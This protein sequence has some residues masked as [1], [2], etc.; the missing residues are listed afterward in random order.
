MLEYR[1]AIS[2]ASWRNALSGNN[3]A[4]EGISAEV[5]RRPMTLDVHAET[6]LAS[7][8]SALSDK[9]IDTA[10][11]LEGRIFLG[12]VTAVEIKGLIEEFGAG[13]PIGRCPLVSKR[14]LALLANPLEIRK[15]I[16]DS[17][18]DFV[19][20]VNARGELLEV[21]PVQH[22]LERRTYENPV[23]IMAG[24]R[25]LRLRPLTETIPKPLI[26]VGEKPIISYIVE[27]LLE[28][29]F[30]RYIV[31]VN[32]L[33]E[34]IIEYMENCTLPGIAI[35]YITESDV[36]GTA[37]ALHLLVH[38]IDTPFIVHNA[39]VLTKQDI[40]DLL[41]FHLDSKAA[42]TVLGKSERVEVS[43]GVIETDGKN[44]LSSIEEKPSFD[45]LI[46]TGI[47][48]LE[49][50][51]LELVPPRR[52]DMV[53]LIQAVKAKG[54]TVAVYETKKYWRDVGTHET[55]AQVVRDISN[56]LL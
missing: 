51:V 35:E 53:E 50:E 34:Q 30:Y 28:C 46:S 25:G 48:V 43:F 52:Y 3:K 20:F 21:L 32:Y 39:D 7:A 8:L 31:A 47:Y 54:L 9:G 6:P 13:A 22:A 49:P 16:T 5:S 33:K 24:G 2:R 19:P 36:M 55:Y 18:L 56:G 14:A 37:G 10:I 40:G 23:V 15:F 12:I 29:G 1:V 26:Q 45:Y 4:V 17:N 11:V 41:R 44:C 27:H 38:K 42:I